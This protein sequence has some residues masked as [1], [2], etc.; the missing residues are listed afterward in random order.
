MSY[1]Q[2]ILEALERQRSLLLLVISKALFDIPNGNQARPESIWMDELTY[3]SWRK[4]VSERIEGIMSNMIL[5]SQTLPEGDNICAHT[6][7]S[8]KL[9]ALWMLATFPNQESR[10]TR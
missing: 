4:F 6:F 10:R 7:F 1:E 2:S 3:T 8:P 5:V 9:S